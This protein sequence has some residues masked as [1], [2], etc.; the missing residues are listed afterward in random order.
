MMGYLLVTGKFI[1]FL[2]ENSKKFVASYSTA[3]LNNSLLSKD[4]LRTHIIRRVGH[5]FSLIKT[6]KVNLC[7]TLRH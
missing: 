7:L 3:F 5:E 4:I 2:M 1:S 6:F